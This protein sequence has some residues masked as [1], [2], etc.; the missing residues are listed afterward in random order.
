M[1][2]AWNLE[3]T[4]FIYWITI[5]KSSKLFGVIETFQKKQYD[6]Q[7]Y[8][9]GDILWVSF[10]GQTRFYGFAIYILPEED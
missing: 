1:L 8:V 2:F 3:H 9:S 10:Y 7:Y 5:F 6:S 4:L